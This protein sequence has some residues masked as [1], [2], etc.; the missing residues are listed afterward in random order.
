[1]AERSQTEERVKAELAERSQT[2]ERV[3][4][5]LAERSKTRKGQRGPKPTGSE[6]ALF[7]CP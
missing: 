2:E 5:E 3:K 1:L 4:A 6:T 7:L